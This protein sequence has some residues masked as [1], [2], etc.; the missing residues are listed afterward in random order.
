MKIPPHSHLNL[1]LF[2]FVNVSM[3]WHKHFIAFRNK[4]RFNALIK[5]KEFSMEKLS[6][7]SLR[8]TQAL[9]MLREGQKNLLMKYPFN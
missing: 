6:H 5:E 8:S 7:A 4:K 3:P 1:L 2:Y 9:S